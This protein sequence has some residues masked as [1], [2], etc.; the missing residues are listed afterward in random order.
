MQ[1]KITGITTKFIAAFLT[2]KQY[3]I[4]MKWSSK[5]NNLPNT[6]AYIKVKVT[7]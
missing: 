7:K 4:I 5:K 3:L 6:I 2:K 1:Q